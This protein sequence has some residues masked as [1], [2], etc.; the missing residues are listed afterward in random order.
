MPAHGTSVADPAKLADQSVEQG[1]NLRGFICDRVVA[2]FCH[3]SGLTLPMAED[4]ACRYQDGC[5][6]PLELMEWGLTFEEI[7]Q[8]EEAIETW[9]LTKS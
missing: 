6:S 5:T 2:A 7:A 8:A 1:M 9:K 3:A 4:W